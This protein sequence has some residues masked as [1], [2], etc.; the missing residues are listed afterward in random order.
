M[1]D[2]IG[3]AVEIWEDERFAGLGETAR[4]LYLFLLTNGRL[5]QDEIYWISKED[6]RVCVRLTEGALDDLRRVGL[7]EF[8]RSQDDVYS[9]EILDASHYQI[10]E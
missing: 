2:S 5:V 8:G 3:I 1:S 7:I 10:S 4:M 9:I 6:I